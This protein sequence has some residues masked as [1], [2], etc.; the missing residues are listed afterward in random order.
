MVPVFMIA[1]DGFAFR[2]PFFVP[3]G[4]FTLLLLYTILAQIGN[5]VPVFIV[6]DGGATVATTCFMPFCPLTC[7]FFAAVFT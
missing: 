3:F 2:T 7:F 6:A 1:D 5:S 4:P